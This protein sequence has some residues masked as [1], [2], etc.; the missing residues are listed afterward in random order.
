MSMIKSKKNSF[1]LV[2]DGTKKGTKLYIGNRIINNIVAI[3]FDLENDQAEKI[4][5]EFTIKPGNYTVR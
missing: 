2:S 3:H 4:D 5:F 1:I